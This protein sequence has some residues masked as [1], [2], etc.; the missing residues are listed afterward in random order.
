M[1]VEANTLNSDDHRRVV[2]Q[3][4]TDI[5]K[6][7]DR[8]SYTVPTHGLYPFQWNWDSCLVAIGQQQLDEK[9]AWT[10]LNTLFDHQWDDGMVPHIIFHELDEGYFPGPDVWGTGRAVQTTGITQPA[11]AGFAA[12]LL[13]KRATDKA[14][15]DD[16]A[17]ALLT[18]IDRWHEWFYRCRDPEGTGLVAV[19]HPWET[20][21]DNSVD[22]DEAL[23]AV[24]T[25]GLQPYQ[26]RDLQHADATHRPTMAQYD[27]YISLVQH[28]RDLSWDNEVLHDAS[29]FRMVDPGFNA[30]LIRACRELAILA[31][32]LGDRDVARRNHD[33]VAAG[34]QAIDSLWSDKHQQYLCFDRVIGRLVDSASVAG[35]LAAFAPIPEARMQALAARIDKL[36]SAVNY[37]VPSHDPADDR[38]DGKRYWR[39]PAWLII[40]YMI[41][42]GLEQGGCNVLAR[43]IQTASLKLID[44]SGFAEYYDPQ[45]GEPC[46]G[47]TFTWTAAMVMEFIQK[48]GKPLG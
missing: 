33:R 29:P 10:E 44:K 12:A 25:E 48:P 22:W 34:L 2:Y 45:S 21:R 35:L 13:H 9:R 23:A 37:L 46:G 42:N 14:L 20:G 24:P 30:I 28:F 11:V 18:R 40:N 16:Q 39:G 6:L 3:R 17:R 47:S 19:I 27:G 31:E 8:G 15:A 38:Y 36:G 32:S 43:R 5:L 4:A 1:S 7:N 26:R 41:A